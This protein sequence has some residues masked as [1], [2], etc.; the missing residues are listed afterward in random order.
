MMSKDEAPENISRPNFLWASTEP[1]EDMD[2]IMVYRSPLVRW[3]DPWL[4]PITDRLERK[5]FAITDEECLDDPTMMWGQAIRTYIQAY[6]ACPGEGVEHSCRR[7]RMHGL[8]L[9]HQRQ[10][11]QA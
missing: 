9:D 2:L 10:P 3:S 4:A 5:C 1:Q 11:Q 8:V 6:H 7:H